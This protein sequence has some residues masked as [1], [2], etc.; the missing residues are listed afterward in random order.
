VAAVFT[1][2]PWVRTPQQVVE[3]LFRTGNQPPPS[4]QVPPRPENKRGVGQ[5]AQRQG[6]RHP[7]GGPGDAT[8]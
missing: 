2:D 5:F 6:C 1:K 8:P 4:G 3:S 7:G